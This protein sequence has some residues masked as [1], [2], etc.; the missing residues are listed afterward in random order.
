MDI[1]TWVGADLLNKPSFRQNHTIKEFIDISATDIKF[2]SSIVAKYIL[3]TLY[4]PKDVIDILIQLVKMFRCT[5][6]E[7]TPQ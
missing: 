6:K 3:T 4:T 1:A 5:V 2:R 7:F